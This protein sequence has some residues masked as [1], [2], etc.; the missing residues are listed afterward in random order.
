MI[1][2]IYGM[3]GIKLYMIC[4]RVHNYIATYAHIYIEYMHGWGNA[5]KMTT[6]TISYI[7]IIMYTQL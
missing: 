7:L 3:H 4:M 1:I 5:Y 2:I 6:Y